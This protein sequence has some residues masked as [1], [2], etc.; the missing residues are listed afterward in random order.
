MIDQPLESAYVI[1]ASICSSVR[2]GRKEN[3]P[4]CESHVVSLPY[5]D[6][7]VTSTSAVSVEV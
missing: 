2:S 3:V 1:C 6:V 4:L 5:A 7:G